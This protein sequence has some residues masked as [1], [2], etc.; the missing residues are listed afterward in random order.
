MQ[1][2]NLINHKRGW[3]S[4]RFSNSLIPSDIECGLQRYSKGEKHDA[5]Y[6]KLCD[7]INLVVIGKCLFHMYDNKEKEVIAEK[8]DIII[9]EAGEASQFTAL[10]DCIIL[11]IKTSSNPKDK[12][13]YKDKKKKK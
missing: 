3:L 10:T 11:C 8:D 9:I 7:E 2:D 5:H 12:Y 4:G 6:H 1:K 13:P